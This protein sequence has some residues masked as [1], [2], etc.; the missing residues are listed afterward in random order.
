[1]QWFAIANCKHFFNY[2]YCI[3]FVYICRSVVN[4]DR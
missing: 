2:M 3:G 1:M 4:C